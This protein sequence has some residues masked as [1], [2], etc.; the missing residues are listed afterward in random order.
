MQAKGRV[1]VGNEAAHVVAGEDGA[2]VDPESEE[3]H[4]AAIDDLCSLLGVGA[5]A[6][7]PMDAPARGRHEEG[8]ANRQEQ[9]HHDRGN[10]QHLQA[11]VLEQ[12]V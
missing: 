9:V 4:H 3:L 11:V 12:R 10:R 6:N 1:V 2:E 8:K 7:L 5:E